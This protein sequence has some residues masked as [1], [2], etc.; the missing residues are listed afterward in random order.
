MGILAS[1]TGFAKIL[2]FAAYPIITRL[3]SPSDFGILSVF[4]SSIAILV[5][6]AT[7]RYSVTIPLPKN[8]GLALNILTLG[9]GLTLILAAV[10]SFIF[11]AVGKPIFGFFNMVEIAEYWWLLVVG[12]TGMAF[13]E[14]LSNWA[15]RKRE[16][17]PVAKTTIWQSFL[18]AITKIG[19]GWAGLKPLGLLIGDVI[20]R[21]GG[22]VSLIRYFVKD[23]KD[24]IKHVSEKKISFLFRYYKDLPLFRLPSQF[25]LVFSTKIPVLYFAFKFGSEATGQL[26]LSLVVVGIP[27]GLIGSNTAKAYYAEIARIGANKKEKILALTTSVTKRLSLLSLIPTLI[28]IFFSPFLFQLIFGRD[29]EEAGVFTSILALYLFFQFVTAPIMNV[30]NV[31]NNQSKFLQINLVRSFLLI[32]VFWLSFIFDLNAYVTLIIYSIILSFHY[33]IIGFQVKTLLST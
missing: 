14:L 21:S 5:P 11:I 29:W 9:I 30:F 33:L 1:G 15:T 13:Y 3:Y 8:D 20:S 12:I 24:N 27:M 7:L 31:L 23:F 2:G 25:L 17:S 18:S 6:F 22:V 32:I 19:L 10:L 28:L 26:G 16:F 4:T